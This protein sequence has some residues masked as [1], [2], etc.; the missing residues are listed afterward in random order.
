[1]TDMT[2]VAQI[3]IRCTGCNRRLADLVNEV[4]GGRARWRGYHAV[5]RFALCGVA[6]GKMARELARACLSCV[7]VTWRPGQASTTIHHQP[8]ALEPE[9]AVFSDRH[10]WH[11]K[12][13]MRAAVRKSFHDGQ[14]FFPIGLDR[15]RTAAYTGMPQ[16]AAAGSPEGRF[17]FQVGGP[18]IRASDRC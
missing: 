2:T 7:V 15:G 12:C 6:D 9:R 1:M 14:E 8:I 17:I 5:E 10:V 11:P 16:V 13:A 4:E 18:Q 3:Q